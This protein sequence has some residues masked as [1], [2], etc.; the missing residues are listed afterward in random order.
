MD[1]ILVW[2]SYWLQDGTQTGAT[3]EVDANDPAN[4][5]KRQ[6]MAMHGDMYG[7]IADWEEYEEVEEDDGNAGCDNAGF[8][9]GTSCKYYFTQCYAK[10]GGE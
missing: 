2:V 6:L 10:E 8:C 4:D 9:I 3:L 5:I 1:K 7:D